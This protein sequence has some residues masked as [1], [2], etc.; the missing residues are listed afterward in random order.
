MK[1]LRNRLRK[2]LGVPDF[3]ALPALPEDT[4]KIKIDPSAANLMLLKAGEPTVIQRRF[5]PPVLPA[6]VVGDFV[7][8]E[9]ADVGKLGAPTLALDDAANAPAWAYLNQ[10]NCGLNFPGYG[11]LSELSQRTE[12]RAPV[13]T[14]ASEMT[15]EWIELTVKGKGENVEEESDDL[16]ANDALPDEDDEGVDA[17]GDGDIDGG[18]EDKIEQL[19]KGLEEFRVRD[20]F[21][22]LIE[23]DG[24]FGRGQLFINIQS[25]NPD[26][27]NQL[28][29]VVSPE[30]IK[31]GS[32][33]GFK[34][35]EP[36]WTTPYNYNST[37]PT[38]G[39]FYKPR[40]W[41]VIGKRVHSSRLLTF[42]SREVPDILKPA[43]NFG[44]LSLTQLMEPYVFQWL[45]TRNSVSDLVHNFSV[46]ILKTDMGAVLAGDPA[47]SKGFF[48]RIR[49][50]ISSRDNQ[51][52]SVLDKNREE[53]Q[54]VHA[55]LAN[56]DKLQ[57]QSQEHMAAPSH[58]PLVKL[59]GITPGGLNASSEGE[60][61]VWYDH[62]RSLQIFMLTAHL[63]HILD[64]L[65]L[66]LFGEIDESIGF[67]FRPLSSPTAKELS[68]M[69]KSDG[70]TDKNYVDMGAVSPDEVREKV[71]ADPNS[72]Y[73]NLSGNAP[74]P[75][76]VGLMDKEH[77]L[78]QEG[79]E[80]EFARQQ[81]A[82][83][84]DHK[85]EG[86]S[87]TVSHKRKLKEIVTAAKAKPKPKPPGKR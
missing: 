84:E 37:D 64:I 60:I 48:D 2:W 10:N 58:I 76:E 22:K 14:I 52:L 78:G 11:Y 4:G 53:M 67:E 43:Y 85:R 74:G 72:G 30:T 65:Q 45:R 44:G 42:M 28:P 26:D 47:A 54:E 86:V 83:K 21:R 18:L 82:A 70:E 63:K 68:E 27:E 41:F 6:E 39:D 79:A 33:L 50:F 87:A 69:R 23:L 17:D 5:T 46:M 80:A 16:V 36:I 9:K 20:H 40:A 55:S 32:L 13:E 73:N 57:A 15:R 34:V 38:R 51:G 35:I 3:V 71:A 66:H 24:M 12:Y 1:W 81:K 31:K 56:L 59:I 77:E 19:E 25:S 49:L 62:V 8:D 7:Y 29:L 75:P 61:Q